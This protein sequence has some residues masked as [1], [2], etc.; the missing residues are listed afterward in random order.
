MLHNITI[1]ADAVWFAVLLNDNA[2]WV[3]PTDKSLFFSSKGW[4]A[5]IGG[6]RLGAKK[7][8]VE[9]SSTD[10]INVRLEIYAE[11]DQSVLGLTY[12][13]DGTVTISSLF[14]QH[15]STTLDRFSLRLT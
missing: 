12:V 4:D 5:S 11:T 14:D 13:A 9:S 6:I 10:S 15:T 1:V 7:L 8:L 3:L 2:S